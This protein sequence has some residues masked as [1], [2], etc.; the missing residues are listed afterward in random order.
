[1]LIFFVFNNLVEL[2]HNYLTATFQPAIYDHR[3]VNQALFVSIKL[4]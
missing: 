2:A 3:K 1:M 4:Q